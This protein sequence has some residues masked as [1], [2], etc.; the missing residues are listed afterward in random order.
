MR[1]LILADLHIAKNTPWS[2][3]YEEFESLIQQITD[4][5]EDLPAFDA[6]I[7]AG[8]IF[9]TSGIKP[10]DIACLERLMAAFRVCC[11]PLYCVAGNHDPHDPTIADVLPNG[12]TLTPEPENIGGLTISGLGYTPDLD[13]VRA[14]LK[15]TTTDV[16]VCHQSVK[17]FINVG[18]IAGDQL[19]L[20]DFP[21]DRL[22]IVGD[23]HITAMREHGTGVVVSPGILTP[24]RSRAELLE[25]SP[26]LVWFDS[27]TG[28]QTYDL[29][30]RY[31]LYF[32]PDSR[33]IQQLERYLNG[34]RPEWD[35]APVLYV[36]E[37]FV[38]EFK[39]TKIPEGAKVIMVP[40]VT[41]EVMDVIPEVD[42][43]DVVAATADLIR[44]TA[45]YMID[46]ED[47]DKA[48]MVTLVSDLVTSDSPEENVEA[49]LKN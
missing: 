11:K 37:K 9:N 23:T 10:A 15:E 35:L 47:K 38:E 22:C 46:D 41:A 6:C 7:I 36:S 17:E 45:A 25:S 26:Q 19:R 18:D 1:I 39:A 44:D 33:C 34:E 24:M 4:I 16:V 49:F 32:D 27:E 14:Y 31:A 28:M 12:G 8:D 42:I 5:G 3:N 30:K 20:D 21:K 40:D 13:K 29:R 43:D 2:D 48:I